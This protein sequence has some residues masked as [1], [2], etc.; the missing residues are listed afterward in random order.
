MRGAWSAAPSDAQTPKVWGEAGFAEGGGGCG[1]RAGQ[2]PSDGG[3]TGSPSREQNVT[4]GE[5]EKVHHGCGFGPQ[6]SAE[7]LLEWKMGGWD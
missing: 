7:N 6:T 2:P 4:G 1:G 3:L 5:G